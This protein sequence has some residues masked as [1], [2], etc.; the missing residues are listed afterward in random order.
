MNYLLFIMSDDDPKKE[1][2]T[3][4]RFRDNAAK[5]TA[6]REIQFMKDAADR[7]ELRYQLDYA[8]HLVSEGDPDTAFLYYSKAK[9]NPEIESDVDLKV[10]ACYGLGR[11][12][13]LK[14]GNNYRTGKS[15]DQ[16]T[17][18]YQLALK[19]LEFPCDVYDPNSLII[20]GDINRIFGLYPSS[21]NYLKL[22]LEGG[23]MDALQPLRDLRKDMHQ[24]FVKIMAIE[25]SG[26]MDLIFEQVDALIKQ[27][28]SQTCEP[29]DKPKPP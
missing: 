20:V 11:L 3:V 17:R 9:N 13:Y 26:N 4:D 6:E 23:Q 14:A 7:G 2:S 8:D 22:A 5:K 1:V 21:M 10:W 19:Y 27:Y 12:C 24:R 18:Q 25:E 29:S 16:V 28:E 15:N